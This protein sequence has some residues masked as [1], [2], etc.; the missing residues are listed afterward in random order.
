[1][2]WRV[3]WLVVVRLVGWSIRSDCPSASRW[4]PAPS[5]S[6]VGEVSVRSR[7]SVAEWSPV[8]VGSVSVGVG[9]VVGSLG[10]SVGVSVGVSEVGVSD[11]GSEVVSLGVRLGVC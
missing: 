7:S 10:L 8:G 9:S 1:M 3:V 5:V 2:V 6:V 4:E 11:G